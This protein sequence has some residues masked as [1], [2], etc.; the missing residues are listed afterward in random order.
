MIL[1]YKCFNKDLTNN[2]GFKF[3]VGKSYFVDGEIKAGING[4]GF[5]MCKNIEDTFRYYGP[6]NLDI[7]VCEVVGSGKRVSFCDKYNGYYDMYSVGKIEILRQLN[8]NEIIEM[9][10]VFNSI[11]SIKID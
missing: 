4:N 2:Y 10:L 8:R 3:E 9:A 7:S 11:W 5:H 1:G 6:M